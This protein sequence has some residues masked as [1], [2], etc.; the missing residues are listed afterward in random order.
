MRS[1]CATL[2]ITQKSDCKFKTSL[3]IKVKVKVKF[4]LEHAT[5]FQRGNKSIALHFL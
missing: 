1:F 3:H 2:Y 4:T 5:K